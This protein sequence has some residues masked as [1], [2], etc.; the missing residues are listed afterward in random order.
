MHY[1]L[2][3]EVVSNYAERRA[4]FRAV[5]LA[6]AERAVE[7]GELLLAGALADP[8]DGAVFLFQ[9]DSPSFAEAFAQSDPYVQNGLV[10][11]WYV[12]TWP[13]VVGANAA[14]PLSSASFKGKQP[15]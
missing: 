15:T 14:T 8:I 4:P 1:L 12:R 3:Y 5:H 7:R 2:F 11:R 9:G 10:T 6:L 13:T